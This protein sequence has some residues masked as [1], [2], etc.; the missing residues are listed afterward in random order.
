M[1]N[2]LKVIEKFNGTSNMSK[3]LGYNGDS[4]IR[5]WKKVGK[6]PVW[7]NKEI[8]SIAKKEVIDLSDCIIV[9][10]K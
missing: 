3:A 7:R 4:K 10:D 1:Y 8:E 9:E 2:A 5:Y 6:I